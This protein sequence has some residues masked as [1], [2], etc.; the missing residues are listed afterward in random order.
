MWIAC[1]RGSPYVQKKEPTPWTLVNYQLVLANP[2]FQK[3]LL[4]SLMV[5]IGS[6]AISLLI[7]S[8]AAYALGRFR[9]RGK[10]MIM[11]IILA[12]SVFPQIAVLGGLFTLI[13]SAGLFNNPAGLILSYLIFTIPFTV[14]VLTS[15]HDGRGDPADSD[16]RILAITLAPA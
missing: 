13:R 6:V 5:A 12:V 8:F 10:Q 16:D 3:G 2:S 1:W 15:N 7:G 9:F 4:F 11:Y 14:W